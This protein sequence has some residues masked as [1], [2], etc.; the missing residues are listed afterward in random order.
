M[1]DQQIQRLGDTGLR[2]KAR[3]EL[4]A[5]RVENV[6]RCKEAAARRG[7]ILSR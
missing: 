2:W 5:G 4:A 6:E 1:T 3:E 7:F